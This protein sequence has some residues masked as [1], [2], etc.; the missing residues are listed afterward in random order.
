MVQIWKILPQ[1]ILVTPLLYNII[2]LIFL[3]LALFSLVVYQYETQK[4][5]FSRA[6]VRYCNVH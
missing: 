1:Y 4:P 2:L 6:V 3:V 5:N